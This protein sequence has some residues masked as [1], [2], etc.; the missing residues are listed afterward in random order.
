MYRSE[1]LARPDGKP[2][3]QYGGIELVDIRGTRVGRFLHRPQDRCRGSSA[4][5][6]DDFDER[7]QPFQGQLLD[8]FALCCCDPLKAP[9]NV[10]RYFDVQVCHPR[11]LPVRLCRM[12]EAEAKPSCRSRSVRGGISTVWAT[13]QPSGFAETGRCLRRE[14]KTPS[15]GGT[16]SRDGAHGNPSVAPTICPP[17]RD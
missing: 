3:S 9:H 1:K 14:A 12:A 2:A 17:F 11:T 15:G 4:S 6:G 8:A 13:N 16:E 7:T 5:F 10:V